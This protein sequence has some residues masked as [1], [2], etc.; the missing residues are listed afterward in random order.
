MH[1]A[2]LQLSSVEIINNTGIVVST[3]HVVSGDALPQIQQVS[4]PTKCCTLKP[5]DGERAVLIRGKKDWGICI[6]KWHGFVKGVP[7][8][9]GEQS[10][11]AVLGEP[12]ELRAKQEDYCSSSS[13]YLGCR[14]GN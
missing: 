12:R 2:L 11:I 1:S 9:A 3:A 5:E 7:G 13:R 14:D 6:G 4:D 10:A 8:V